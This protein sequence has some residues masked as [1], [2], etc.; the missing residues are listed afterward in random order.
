MPLKVA[1]GVMER[2]VTV[3]IAK[4][5]TG[6]IVRGLAKECVLEGYTADETERAMEGLYSKVSYDRFY[7]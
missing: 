2:V 7:C 3:P 6:C 5:L 1:D 4:N